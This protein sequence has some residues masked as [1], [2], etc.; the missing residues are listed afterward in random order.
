MGLMEDTHPEHHMFQMFAEPGDVGFA[1]TARRRTWV[2]GMHQDRSTIRQDPYELL[3]SVKGLFANDPTTVQDYLVASRAEVLLEAS[4]LAQKRRIPFQADCLDLTYL[5]TQREKETAAALNARFQE[6][7]GRNAELEPA[8]VYH[9]GDSATF[10][11]WSAVSGRIPTY[12]VGAKSSVYWLPHY[13]RF[14]TAKEKL[15]SMGWPSVPE[16]ASSMHVPLFGASDPR[17]AGDLLG[18][19]MHMQICG[20]MQLLALVSFSPNL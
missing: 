12:R 14:L 13:K 16:I 2:I 11:S 5:L 8:L 6:Q 10:G 18:N 1:A 19:A 9:L 20:L 7:F 3:E 17:R 4:Q 15:I